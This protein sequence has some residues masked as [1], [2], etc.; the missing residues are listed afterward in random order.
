MSDFG[1]STL[2]F[3]LGLRM[4]TRYP[5]LAVVGVMSI[6]LAVAA[7]AAFTTFS[8]NFV[9]PEL[10]LAEGDRVV[11]IQ[12]W[13]L[14]ANSVEPRALHNFVEWRSELG[15]V[16]DVG[17]FAASQRTMETSEGR[18]LSV[19]AAEITAA[20][21]RVAR[22]APLLGRPLLEE[23]ERVG[24]PNVAVIGYEFWQNQLSADSSVIGSPILLGDVP[25]TVVGVMPARFGSRSIRMSGRHSGT[26]R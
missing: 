19:H 21:F 13:D 8:Q 2:D 6:S 11:T 4:V 26:T 15:T 24:A 10:P 9:D 7:T 1:V 20:G 23:D 17:A 5:L 3:R 18:S 16:E 25:H 22:Q 12:N 14:V